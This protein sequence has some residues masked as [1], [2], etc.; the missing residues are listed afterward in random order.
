MT[1][2]NQALIVDFPMSTKPAANVLK[3]MHVSSRQ[4]ILFRNRCELMILDG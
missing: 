1:S 4:T 2:K 3:C